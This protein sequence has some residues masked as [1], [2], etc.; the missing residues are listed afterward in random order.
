MS[1]GLIYTGGTIG[2]AGAPLTAL[3]G[4][5]FA[6]RLRG[7]VLEDLPGDLVI[8]HTDPTLDSTAMTPADW[9]AL[10]HRV[11]D[12]PEDRIVILHGTDTMAWTAAA[13]RFLLCRYDAT[14]RVIGQSG[15]RIAIT[16]AQVPL[17]PGGPR[18]PASDGF[19]NL[20]QAVSWVS[21]EPTADIAIT[22]GGEVV[23]AA[24][25]AKTSSTD[26]KAFAMPNG[27]GTPPTCV[28]VANSLPDPALS[29][30]FGAYQVM[31]LTACPGSD[32]AGQLRGAM[33]ALGPSLGAV[34]LIGY[35]IGN[36][37]GEET[38]GPMLAEAH[39]RGILLAVGSQALHGGVSP[40]TYGV[41]HWMARCGVMPAGDMTHAAT[42]VKLHMAMAMGVAHG[43]D[44]ETTARFF[45]RS[46]VG[47]LSAP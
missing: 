24:R 22:F 44:H 10:A 40:Q 1:V 3:P 46:V 38:L 13:L 25:G 18:D 27:P 17:F 42:Q 16:G 39:R 41:G 31:T 29:P 20:R 14:G 2:C 35:G 7:E 23:D 9:L 32:L 30:H 19:D 15:K 28:A 26:F 21:A 34:H 43:W 12:A 11:A 47:E 33:T 36:M 8:S 45:G 4:P 6:A 5:D 37:P